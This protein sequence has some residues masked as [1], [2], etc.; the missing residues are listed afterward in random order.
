MPV[1]CAKKN[2]KILSKLSSDRFFSGHFIAKH[3]FSE[4]GSPSAACR[5]PSARTTPRCPPTR[6]ARS[7]DPG[8][9][10]I[11][12]GGSPQRAEAGAAAVAAAAAEG[13]RDRGTK[14]D[15]VD[16]FDF[17]YSLGFPHF[18][19]RTNFVQWPAAGSMQREQRKIN[20]IVY[21]LIFNNLIT[22][23]DL[24]FKRDPQGQ[25]I[26]SYEEVCP[27][28]LYLRPSTFFALWF[29]NEEGPPSYEVY[30]YLFIL[31]L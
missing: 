30:L 15:S 21:I 22:H 24:K 16:V 3:V 13:G 20:K 10:G 27:K 4:P 31:K 14:F 26:P 9:G 19:T 29:Q 2:R 25:W 28:L 17:N 5:G 6:T 11:R 7:C 8:S 12:P 18:Q 1:C 23:H